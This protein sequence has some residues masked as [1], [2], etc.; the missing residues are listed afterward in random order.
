MRGK[1]LDDFIKDCSGRYIYRGSVYTYAET[2]SLPRRKAVAYLRLL[3]AAAFALAL[4]QGCIPA[5]GMLGCVYVL[6][7]YCGELF[8]AGSALWALFPLGSGDA[9]RQYNFAVSAEVLPRRALLTAVFAALTLAGEGV[10]LIIHGTDNALCIAL[11]VL[12]MILAGAAAMYLRRFVLTLRWEK[13]NTA[14]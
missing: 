3:T 6:V 2:N 11:L 7:P 9:I 4:A 13:E 8:S 14:D 5:D 1:Y 12:F 10:Y